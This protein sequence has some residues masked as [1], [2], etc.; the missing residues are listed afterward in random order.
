MPRGSTE[1]EPGQLVR[2]NWERKPVGGQAVR[3][4][5]N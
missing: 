3:A 2:D 1:L 5:M 4:P